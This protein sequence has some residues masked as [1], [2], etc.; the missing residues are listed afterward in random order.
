MVGTPQ[1]RF[2][3]PGIQRLVRSR[4]GHGRRLGTV[5]YEDPDG[6]RTW[7]ADFEAWVQMRCLGRIAGRARKGA[8]PPCAL[9]TLQQGRRG[10]P[11]TAAHLLA[12]C[13]ETAGVV[14]AALGP[15]A[16]DAALADLLSVTVGGFGPPRR[17]VCAV[18]HLVGQ[19]TR[20]V[21]AS[22]QSAA[23]VED[24]LA[25]AEAQPAP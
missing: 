15:D 5:V 7:W 24:M 11:E 21:R 23:A 14:A 22:A 19:V 2:R 20:K 18:V 17:R 4:R 12:E 16:R 1:V 9:C 3:A 8:A 25:R 13:P 10:P 6:G